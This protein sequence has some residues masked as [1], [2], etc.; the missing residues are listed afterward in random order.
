MVTISS[1]GSSVVAPGPT[2]PS[3]NVPGQGQPAAAPILQAATPPGGVA[4]VNGTPNILTWTAPNDGQNHRV[5]VF[6][7]K[8]VT[9]T[10][11]GG[12]IA[13]SLGSTGSIQTPYAGGSSAAASPIVPGAGG[14]YQYM[15]P[16]GATVTISQS[17]AL[18]GGASKINAEIWAS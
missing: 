17:S 2:G 16:P 14:F 3:P 13:I 12:G 15:V 6:L 9:V 5:T 18:T 8:T 11:V 1:Q 4:L 10:E 7:V